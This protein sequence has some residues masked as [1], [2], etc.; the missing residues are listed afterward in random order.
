MFDS[1]R[2]RAHALIGSLLAATCMG[3]ANMNGTQKGAALGAAGGAGLG[4]IIGH[5]FGSTGA[6]AAIGALAG[7]ATGALAGNM[8]DEADEKEAYA[9]QAAYERTQRRRDARAVTN[10]D[11]ADMVANGVPDRVVVSTIQDR[12]GAFDMSPQAVI[13]LHNS[14]VSDAVIQ[15]M[16]HYNSRP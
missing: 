7:T 8:K 6:G 13:A 14:G 11:V 12:G 10:R 1:E 3:C 15:S 5:Q 4:A 2:L 16:Q 9:R